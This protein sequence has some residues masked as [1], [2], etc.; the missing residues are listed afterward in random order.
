[1]DFN[2]SLHSCQVFWYLKQVSFR[3]AGLKF[4]VTVA[5]FRKNFVIALAPAFNNG[6]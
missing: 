1:M 5:I 4:K 6:F 2:I 3:V